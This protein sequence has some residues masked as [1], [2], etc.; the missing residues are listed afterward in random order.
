M[1][2]VFG[3]YLKVTLNKKNCHGIT[4]RCSIVTTKDLNC[5]GITPFCPFNYERILTNKK[6]YSRLNGTLHSIRKC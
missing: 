6:K 1:M 2:V 4:L 5:H 3:V